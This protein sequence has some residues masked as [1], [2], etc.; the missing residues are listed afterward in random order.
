MKYSSLLCLSFLAVLTACQSESGSGSSPKKEV[1]TETQSGS[2][3][4]AESN[5]NTTLKVSKR[6]I[7]TLN[8][9]F[10]KSDFILFKENINKYVITLQAE[11][12]DFRGAQAECQISSHLIPLDDKTIVSFDEKGLKA[13]VELALQPDGPVNV[14]YRC[15]V[16]DRGIEV[17]SVTVSLKKSILVSKNQNIYALGLAGEKNIEALVLDEGAV[18]TTEG[19]SISL[20]MKEL[21]SNGGTIA[22]FTRDGMPEPVENESGKSGG[23]ISLTTERAIG[24]IVFELRGG[25]AGSQTKIPGKNPYI[26]P[27]DSSLDGQCSGQVEQEYFNKNNQKCWG[28]KGL[29]GQIGFK[30]LRGYDGGSTGL[31]VLK[32]KNAKNFRWDVSY[33]PGRESFGGIGGEGGAPGAGGIGSSIEIHKER[34]DHDPIGPRMK[35]LLSSKPYKYPDGPMGD[36]GSRGEQG[37]SGNPGEKQN[38]QI[39]VDSEGAK[40]EFNFDFKNY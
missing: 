23:I 17:D 36:P 13:E 20:N 27:K 16:I 33:F 32:A 18:L 6:R 8:K 40:Y 5:A 39:I 19:D 35:S 29:Q 21:I 10:S 1:Q 3:E 25:D 9:N 22:T 11:T 4:N 31:V 37:E 7:V 26:L 28:K 38:S 30:G 34:N 2:A 24:D 14:E 15:R 12:G